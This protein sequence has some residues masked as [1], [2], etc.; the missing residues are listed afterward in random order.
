MVS[1]P[2]TNFDR[3]NVSVRSVAPN[4]PSGIARPKVAGRVVADEQVPPRWSR[5]D[6]E[7]EVHK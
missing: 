1:G 4:L 3:L 7:V 6:V 2:E 5:A